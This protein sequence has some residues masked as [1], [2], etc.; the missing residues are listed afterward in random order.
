MPRLQETLQ[1]IHRGR[2]TKPHQLY[3]SCFRARRRKKRPQVSEEKGEIKATASEPISQIAVVQAGGPH[4][5]GQRRKRRRRRGTKIHGAVSKSPQT[6]LGHHIFTKGEWRR[7]QLAD[8]PRVLFSISVDQPAGTREHHRDRDKQNPTEVSAIADTGAQSD[9]WSLEA[10]PASGF[11]RADLH[12]VNLSLAAANRSPIA[13][14]GAFLA[15]LTTNSRSGKVSSCRS[16]VY[17]SNSVRNMYLSYESLLNLNLLPQDFPSNDN[18]DSDTSVDNGDMRTPTP[19]RISATRSINS[20]C[21]EPHTSPDV[22]CS[23]PQRTVP[24]P[25]PKELPFP[26]TPENNDN[27]KAWLIE[28]Y[29]SSTFNTAHI[30]HFRVWTAP[31]IEIHMDPKA[32]PKACHTPANIPVHWQK[33]VYEDLIRDEALGVVERVPYGEPVTWCHRM[34]ISRKHDGSPRRRVDLSP[35]NKFCRR[36]TFA[37]E[38]PFHLARRIPTNTW[39]TVAD[40]WNGYHSVPLRASDRHL[41]T[42][43]TPFGRWRYTRAPQGFL[44]SGDGYNRRFDAIIADFERKERC[45]DDTI[46]YDKDLAQHWRRTIEFL[47]RVGQSGIVLNPDKFQFAQRTVDFAGFRV[48]DTTIEPLPKYMDAIR[49]FPTPD[50]T[51]D[52]RSWFGLVNQVANYAQLRDTMAPFKPFLSPRCKFSWS[53]ELEEAFQ[54]AIVEAIREGVEIFDMQKRT[55]L[56]PDWSR[57]GIGY[58]LLQ[59]HCDCPSSLPDCCQGGWR[60]T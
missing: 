26:C 38:S 48:S 37:T 18:S 25:C 1:N 24:P 43:I 46:H 23:C 41:T 19:P 8:H 39:R 57:R 56:R 21:T 49:E 52:I 32:T 27:M 17:V 7:A 16:M 47:T 35:L 51:T 22:P 2:N 40:A 6:N 4:S 9:L 31:P 55:C 12:P 20:C 30:A 45:I 34:V 60:M 14:D 58:F 59:Q 29:A 28:R 44:S 5:R 11:S 50:S 15:R 36:E 13:I 3:I 53:T 54:K 10:F 42:F 33:K